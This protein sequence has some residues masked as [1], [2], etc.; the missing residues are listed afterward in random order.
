VTGSEGKF[1]VNGNNFVTKAAAVQRSCAIQNNLCANA[2]NA[3]RNAGFSVGD[4][5]TQENQCNA[6]GQ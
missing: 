2:A 3:N 5:N 6:A 4:C 1:V